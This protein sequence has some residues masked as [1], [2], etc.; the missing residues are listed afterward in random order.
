MAGWSYKDWEGR[1]YPAS[2]KGAH[3]LAYLADRPDFRE[4]AERTL[5][6][7]ASKA[8]EYGLFAS[9]YALA[10]AHHL[11]GPVEI[12]VIGPERDSRCEALW[13]TAQQALVPGKRVLA[14][15]AESVARGDLPAGLAATLPHVNLDGGPVALVCSGAAC[16]PPAATP[17]ELTEALHRAGAIR[18][19]PDSPF[20][21]SRPAT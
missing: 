13:R 21:R 14:I 9:T 11:R 6:L 12:V 5:D 1:V 16:Q 3:R 8:G 10:L 17:E 4:K 19:G 18:H 7:F 20:D 15:T 2:L